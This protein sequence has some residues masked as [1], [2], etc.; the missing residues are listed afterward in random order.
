MVKQEVLWPLSPLEG[1]GV[2]LSK[3]CYGLC[4]HLK[5]LVKGQAFALI[6]LSY[7]CT[8]QV[9]GCSIFNWQ[10]STSNSIHV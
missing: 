2:W 1:F 3:R 6:C 8:G 7:I 5:G 10:K 9:E 4:P